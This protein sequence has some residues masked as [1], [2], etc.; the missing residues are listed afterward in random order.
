[1]HYDPCW[2]QATSQ[3]RIRNQRKTSRRHQI[4]KNICFYNFV[5]LHFET[6][7]LLM[8]S[9]IKATKSTI[10]MKGVDF[11]ALGAWSKSIPALKLEDQKR[12]DTL[13]RNSTSEGIRSQF[14]GIFSMPLQSVCTV[15]KFFGG[16]WMG[17]CGAL[18]GNKY[19]CLDQLYED[20]QTGNCLIYSFGI[21]GD[22]TFENAMADLGCTIRAF[23]PTTNEKTKPATS[24]VFSTFWPQL[25]S[26]FY[27]LG[28]RGSK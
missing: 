1:M 13:F 28:I 21:A 2:C 11:N 26:F 9:F 15:G 23:D 20:V 6:S 25:T 10:Q 12:T 19:V 4:E 27:F 14:Y 7:S 16:N 22:W 3:K 17:G 8:F 24:L 5:K 18:D